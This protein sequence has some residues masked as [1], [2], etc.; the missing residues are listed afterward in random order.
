MINADDYYG[1]EAFV[2]VHDFLVEH[3]NDEAH[4]CMPGFI[5][6]NTLSDQGGVSRGIC[7]V[8]D[9]GY[10]T[11]I[12]ETHNIVKK[13]KDFAV[14]EDTGKEI[15][16]SSLAS[17]NIWGVTPDYLDILEAGFVDFLKNIPE[18]DIKAEYL[19]PIIMEGLLKDGRAKISVLETHDKWFGITY[20]ADKEKVIAE[21][22]KLVDKGVYPTPLNS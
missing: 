22:K 12:I 8:D 3:A 7:Q 6:K 14:T 13:D 5:L 21:F 1:K 16:M 10:L 4:Y 2:K 20:A 9:D 17:M 11:E 18:G 15:P 19:L